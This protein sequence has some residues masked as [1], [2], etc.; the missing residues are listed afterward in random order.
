MNTQALMR[1][2]QF[3]FQ[4]HVETIKTMWERHVRQEYADHPNVTFVAELNAKPILNFLV[5]EGVALDSEKARTI[6]TQEI[7]EFKNEGKISYQEF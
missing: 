6:V 7:G 2:K 4:E 5:K 3:S 1:D